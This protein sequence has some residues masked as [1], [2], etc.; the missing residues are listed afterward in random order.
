MEAKNAE[1][2]WR[3]I[4]LFEI[5]LVSSQSY[6]TDHVYIGGTSAQA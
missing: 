6:D 5:V 1:I 4:P 3:G 2:S